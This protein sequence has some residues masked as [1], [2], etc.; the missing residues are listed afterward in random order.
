MSNHELRFCFPPNSN[1]Y[2]EDLQKVVF[3]GGAFFGVGGFV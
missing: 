2:G 1:L 3:R